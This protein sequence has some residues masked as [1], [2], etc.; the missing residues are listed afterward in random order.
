MPDG[1]APSLLLD[2]A[3]IIR[4]ASASLS[5]MMG[6]AP[7]ALEGRPIQALLESPAPRVIETLLAE[8]QAE[9]RLAVRLRLADGTLAEADLWLS[10]L[11]AADGQGRSYLGT[12]ELM[13]SRASDGLLF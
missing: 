2:A 7:R 6:L 12:I 8:L 1:Q 4:M 3:G 13:S 5:E 9:A 10:P 11:P